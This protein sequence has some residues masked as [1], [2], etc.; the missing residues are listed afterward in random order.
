MGSEWMWGK[1]TAPGWVLTYSSSPNKGSNELCP[2][3]S[4]ESAIEVIS[5]FTPVASCVLGREINSSALWLRTE[6]CFM[7]SLVHAWD[8]S[9]IF[10]P[11]WIFWNF[12]IW[13]QNS[14]P[15]L[16]WSE[17][18]IIGWRATERS[19]WHFCTSVSAKSWEGLWL[20]HFLAD[21]NHLPASPSI[22]DGLEQPS[23]ILHPDC[24]LAPHTHQHSDTQPLCQ[25][26]PRN[27]SDDTP[28]LRTSIYTLQE[29]YA[30]SDLWTSISNLYK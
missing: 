22:W 14:A 19:L 28:K 30:V 6:T 29:P 13:E 2:P 20:R 3:A 21:D 12:S 27:P 16:I 1:C 17:L 11:L 9:Y 10:F 18:F 26:G 8:L 4:L 24:W 5:F 15:L 23:C 25:L 7:K